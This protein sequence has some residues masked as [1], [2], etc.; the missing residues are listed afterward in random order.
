MADKQRKALEAENTSRKEEAAERKWPRR[1]QAELE[2]EKGAELQ[3]VFILF[4]VSYIQ[5]RYA[6]PSSIYD[7]YF[8]TLR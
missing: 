7:N 5:E 3:V 1:K 2:R 4:P 6:I 8:P